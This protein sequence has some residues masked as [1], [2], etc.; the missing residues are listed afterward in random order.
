LT[1]AQIKEE[2]NEKLLLD[3]SCFAYFDERINFYVLQRDG[4][5]YNNHSSEPNVEQT[6]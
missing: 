4:T 1:A 6:C 5:Q 3:I 2:K